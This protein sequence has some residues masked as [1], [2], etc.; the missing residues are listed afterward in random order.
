MRSVACLVKVL[1]IAAFLH[2]AGTA[3]AQPVDCPRLA[4]QINALAASGS[5]QGRVTQHYGAAVQKQRNDLDRTIRYCP[6]AWLRPGPIPDV[7]YGAAA[8]PRA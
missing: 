5:G 8:M 6:F 3:A 7:R 2:A 4:A 1:G